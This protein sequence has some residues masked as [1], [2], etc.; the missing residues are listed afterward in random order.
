MLATLPESALFQIAKHCPRKHKQR[1]AV[2]NR[3]MHLYLKS[4]VLNDNA[5]VI[6]CFVRSRCRLF[7]TSVLAQTFRRVSNLRPAWI[8]DTRYGFYLTL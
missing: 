4:E 5:L 8:S 3:G 6:Q 1:M 2:C 7:S